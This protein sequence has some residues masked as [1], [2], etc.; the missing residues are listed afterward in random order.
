[1]TAKLTPIFQ[2]SVDPVRVGVYRW[3]YCIPGFEWRYSLWDGKDWRL[4]SYD[5]PSAGRMPHH[6]KASGHHLFIWRGLAS[7]P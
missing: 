5:V 1:M 2:G 6:L 7:K 3:R 4:P